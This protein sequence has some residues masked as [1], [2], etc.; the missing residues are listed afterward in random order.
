M[1]K[2]NVNK[3]IISKLYTFPLKSGSPIE[4]NT[5]K[6]NQQGPLDDRVFF[7]NLIEDESHVS[8]KTNPRILQISIKPILNSTEKKYR[9]EVPGERPYEFTIENFNSKH[10]RNNKSGMHN[11]VEI[12]IDEINRAISK[13]LEEE[14]VLC[15][16]MKPKDSENSSLRKKYQNPKEGDSHN[17]HDEAPILVIT[18]EQVDEL[19]EKLNGMNEELVNFL[20]FRPNI[21]IKGCEANFAEKP[22]VIKINN[23]TL[24]RVVNCPRCRLINYSKKT[25][26]LREKNTPLEVL[27][28]YKFDP[29]LKNAI[30]GGYYYVDL[31]SNDQYEIKIGDEI[32]VID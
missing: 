21:V 25:Q 14:C 19:N 16:S 7:I 1:E 5:L 15:F 10:I 23:L 3:P 9:L 2:S 12:G 11:L 32:E 31:K 24:R 29:E 6:L 20:T 28:T 8:I 18:E 22:N 27:K 26:K 17:F 13:Y 4:S 30:F